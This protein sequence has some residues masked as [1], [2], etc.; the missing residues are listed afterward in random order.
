MPTTSLSR[1]MGVAERAFLITVTVLSSTSLHLYTV[2]H[3][4][5]QLT[6]VRKIS[7]IVKGK[8]Y[9]Q[10]TPCHFIKSSA[11][12]LHSFVADPDPAVFLNADPDPAVFLN[13]DPDPT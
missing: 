7:I 6:G 1:S 11:V 2:L 8:I 12:D 5:L 13:A 4:I 9:I 3:R 10:T